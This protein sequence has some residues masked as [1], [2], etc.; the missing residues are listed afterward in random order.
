MPVA[1]H[2]VGPGGSQHVEGVVHGAGRD[3]P[4]RVGSRAVTGA[5][6]T[7]GGEGDEVLGRCGWAT[8]RDPE[9]P[10][11]GRRLCGAL[12]DEAPN[13]PKCLVGIFGSQRVRAAGGCRQPV[14]GDHVRR[15]TVRCPCHAFIVGKDGDAQ[16]RLPIPPPPAT[17]STA[18]RSS[19]SSTRS[20]A[21]M[22]CATRMGCGN[23]GSGPRSPGGSGARPTPVGPKWHPFDGPER[24]GRRRSRGWHRSSAGPTTAGVDGSRSRRSG[25]GED[26]AAEEP[27]AKGE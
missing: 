20:E 6:E 15:R 1:R 9:H 5:A 25:L 8:G 16:F 24:R 17:R 12:L 3:F 26:S 19:A 21:A 10:R 18:R 14:V 2:R 11:R 4:F 7:V 13:P 23:R 27:R 22:F